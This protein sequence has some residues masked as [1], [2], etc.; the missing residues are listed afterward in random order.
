MAGENEVAQ[1]TTE[2]TTGTE[3]PATTTAAAGEGGM[4]TLLGEG[5]DP[6]PEG[7]TTANT[8]NADGTKE[9]EE[10]T[11]EKEGGD[12]AADDAPVEYADFQVP[13]GIT[14]DEA[15]LGEFKPIAQ[16][17]KLT[18]DQ[19]QKFVSLYAEKVVA[20]QKAWVDTVAGWAD[21]TRADPEIGGANLDQNM[22]LARTAIEQFGGADLLKQINDYG[23][24]CNPTMLRAWVKVGKALG[25]DRSIAPGAGAGRELTLAERM[26][27]KS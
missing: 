25:E 20:D 9:G 14:V 3:Q 18:Q 5:G 26:Y 1:T 16:E 6:K 8:A 19:A 2:A 10:G 4:P 17:L 13:E 24:G 12:N 11:G 23:L 27:P 15:M 21:E 22:K 7:D